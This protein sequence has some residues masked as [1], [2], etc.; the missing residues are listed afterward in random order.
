MRPTILVIE[1]TNEI[2]ENITEILQ[3]RGFDV[4]AA[5][6]GETGFDMAFQHKP[7]LILC[8]VLMSEMTGYEVLKKLKQTQ[9]ISEIPFV[10]LTSQPELANIQRAFDLGASDYIIK[11]FDG[12]T[13]LSRIDSILHF[14]RNNTTRRS[15]ELYLPQ[16]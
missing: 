4:I 13:L 8:D 6:N 14:R 11:P 2:L 16:P 9:Q 5:S 12:D 15:A 7:D 10:Y 3:L 1:D